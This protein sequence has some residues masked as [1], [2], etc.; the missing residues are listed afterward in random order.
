MKRSEFIAL[1]GAIPIALLLPKLH[2]VKWVPWRFN[3]DGNSCCNDYHEN[4]LIEH[5]RENNIKFGGFYHQDG[6]L[7]MPVFSDGSEMDKSYRGW[8]DIMAKAWEDEYDEWSYCK[9]AWEGIIA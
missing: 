5:I 8:G 4:V 1:A 6:A 2:V 9:Y 7:G 3:L